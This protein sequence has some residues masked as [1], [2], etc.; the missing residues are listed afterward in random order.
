MNRRRAQELFLDGIEYSIRMA[1]CAYERLRENAAIYSP[2]RRD[3]QSLL[4]LLF[5]DAW[6]VVDCVKRLRALVGQ[7]PGLKKTHA[8]ELFTRAVEPVVDFRNY[9][10]HLEGEPSGV[11]ATGWPIWGTLAWIA[12]GAAAD[13]KRLLKSVVAIPGR[14]ASVAVPALNPLGKEIVPPTDHFL[15]S[16]AEAG[17]RLRD[18]IAAVRLFGPRFT[19]AVRKAS[20]LNGIAEED[21]FPIT[22]EET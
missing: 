2:E 3:V 4:D 13:E 10:Q 19:D 14:L 8:V 9:H 20:E 18:V 15:L 7:T 5:L 16:V 22:V 6:S 17:L 1:D 12:V 21:P 11:A